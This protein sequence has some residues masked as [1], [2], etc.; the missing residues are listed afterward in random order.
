M[1]AKDISILLLAL[2]IALLIAYYIKIKP[3]FIWEKTYAN[4]KTQPYDFGIF[5]ELILQKNGAIAITKEKSNFEKLLAK[6]TEKSTYIFIGK[7]CFLT[8]HEQK[9]LIDY[10]KKGNSVMFISETLPQNLLDTILQ[11]NFDTLIHKFF[12]Y[13]VSVS[14]EKKH[15]LTE[16]RHRFYKNDSFTKTNFNFLKP[17]ISIY[18]GYESNELENEILERDEFKILGYVNNEVNFIKKSIGKGAIFFN[19]TPLL[20]TN[21]FIKDHSGFQYLNY[22]LNQLPDNS[23]ILDQYSQEYKKN[24]QQLFSQN[25]TPLSFILSKPAL[26]WAWYLII[27]GAILFLVFGVKRKQKSIPPI[28]PRENTSENFIKSI[29]ALFLR[30]T[31]YSAMGSY[32]MHQFILFLKTKLNINVTEF[33]KNTFEQIS[34]TS[35]VEI[36]VI[37]NIFAKQQQHLKGETLH[38]NK[39]ELIELNQLINTFYKQ[40][41]NKK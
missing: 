12:D 25:Q 24:T 7:H 36:D 1:K 22:C 32:K 39:K 6:N 29:G 14:N 3:D 15:P 38:L 4:T 26:S 17:N 5:N 13:K 31:N 16:F 18:Q 35:K 8:I 19:T 20:F 33:N 40:Y 37:S 34:K 41:K 27:S 2:I 28:E 23:I 30:N 11:Y 21:Y 9:Q 10:T